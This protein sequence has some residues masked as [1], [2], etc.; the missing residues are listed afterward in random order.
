MSEQK[1]KEKRSVGRDE[2]RE[3]S[4]VREEKWGKSRRA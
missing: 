4:R 2:I 3:E 1:G